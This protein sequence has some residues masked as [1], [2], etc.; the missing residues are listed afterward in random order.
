MKRNLYLIL[1]A[2]LLSEYAFGQKNI[3]VSK[4]GTL[5]TLISDSEK[6]TI[7]E[8]TLTGELNGTD[9]RL[10]RDMA[11]NNYKGELTEGKLSRLNLSGATIVEGGENYLDCYQIFLDVS[12]SMTDER[13]FIFSS[14]KN[15]I[16]QWLFVGCNSLREINLPTGTTAI[17]DYAF[18]EC[19]LTKITIPSGIVSIGERAFYHNMYLKA[20]SMPPAL[21]TIG[22]NAFSYCSGLAEMEIPAGVK[23]IGKNAFSN[24]KALVTVRSNMMQPCSITEK[25]FSVYDKATLYIPT[26][27]KPLYE[28]TEAWNRFDKIIEHEV[29]GI[30]Q[31]IATEQSYD[32]YTLEGQKVATKASTLDGLRPAIYIVNGKKFIVSHK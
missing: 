2:I 21:T 22:A 27:T 5:P 8:L 1:M 9:L 28:T 13:G 4:A 31:P 6:Y 14:V 17:G 29:S 20:F 24:C 16:P 10:L 25:T 30:R 7:E 26:G 32:I 19:M 12:A 23:E 15:A 3:N 11:G 18:A